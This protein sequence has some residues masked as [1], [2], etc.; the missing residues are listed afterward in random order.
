MN[1]SK[2]KKI[3]KR[4]LY[5]VINKLEQDSKINDKFL[6]MISNLTLEEVIAIKLESAAKASG[7]F[8]YGIQIWS[9]IKDITKEAVLKFALSATQTKMEAA[10]FLGLD[11]FNFNRYVKKYQV[12]NYFPDSDPIQK[13]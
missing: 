13:I 4:K 8:I 10:R 9:A 3:P 5:S 1:Y 11:I 7:G 12:E 6:V 2:R